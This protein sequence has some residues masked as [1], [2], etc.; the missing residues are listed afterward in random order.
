MNSDYLVRS[1]HPLATLYN[2][3]SPAEMHHL[4]AAFQLAGQEEYGLLGGM[5]PK[6]RARALPPLGGV[7]WGP[8][9]R[10]FFR[11]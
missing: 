4:A 7:G 8:L 10:L 11:F 5:S 3:R 9:P 2:D 6:S 1:A